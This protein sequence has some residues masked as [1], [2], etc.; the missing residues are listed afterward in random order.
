MTFEILQDTIERGR[1]EFNPRRKYEQTGAPGFWDSALGQKLGETGREIKYRYKKQGGTWGQKAFWTHT[2][3]DL[4][5]WGNEAFKAKTRPTKEI[6]SELYTAA[7]NYARERGDEPLL[8]ALSKMQSSPNADRFADFALRRSKMQAYT[9]APLGEKDAN[10]KA[11]GMNAHVRTGS[12][13]HRQ[14]ERI[15][16]RMQAEH[17]KIMRDVPYAK[18]LLKMMD[19]WGAKVAKDDALAVIHDTAGMDNITRDKD[20]N[21]DPLAQS[22]FEKYIVNNKD[23]PLTPAEQAWIDSKRG[24]DPR[25]V[26]GEKAKQDAFLKRINFDKLVASYRDNPDLAR[27]AGPWVPFKRFGDHA[28]SGDYIFPEPEGGRHIDRGMFEFY[29]DAAAERMIDRVTDTLGVKL[30]DTDRV[31]YVKDPSKP[32]EEWV[33]A[34][35]EDERSQ[36]EG[37]NVDEPGY[38]VTT[39]Q[40]TRRV[41]PKEAEKDPAL[42]IRRRLNFNDRHVEFFRKEREAQERLDEMNNKDHPKYNPHVKMRGEVEL[43]SDYGGSQSPHYMSR[44]MRGLIENA[45]N[46]WEYKRMTPSERRA[47]KQ[48]LMTAAAKQ[49]MMAGGRAPGLMREYVEGQSRDLLEAYAVASAQSAFNHAHYKHGQRLRDAFKAIDEHNFQYKDSAGSSDRRAVAEEL[50]RAGLCRA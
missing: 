30:L 35:K 3:E 36:W 39:R 50:Q 6:I 48:R 12:M 40:G 43:V 45:T 31:A 18:E 8:H 10:G 33:E 5:R 14:I 25:T 21:I 41:T 16:P 17:E 44:A 29:D 27:R 46:S 20:G 13:L 23:T 1:P 47:W 49:V 15:F 11:T 22:A 37:G 7:H 32:R 28:I 38:V 2:F 9:E 24:P 4:T 34:Q 42:E 19:D 26:T